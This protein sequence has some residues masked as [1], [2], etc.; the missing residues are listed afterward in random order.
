[1]SHLLWPV[2]LCTTV[3][4]PCTPLL[5]LCMRLPLLPSSS[6]RVYHPC[7]SQAV[8]P[9]LSLLRGHSEELTRPGLT[10]QSLRSTGRDL[11][12]SMCAWRAQRHS[13][14]LA[15]HTSLIKM[16]STLAFSP[17][18]PPPASQAFDLSSKQTAEGGG[19]ERSCTEAGCPVPRWAEG[20]QLMVLR[21]S[22]CNQPP[23]NPAL[24]CH[25]YP[26][27]G[28]TPGRTLRASLSTWNP[29]HRKT[30]PSSLQ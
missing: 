30:L 19:T 26:P 20:C 8:F 1:M 6:P 23:R 24:V 17:P 29:L 25:A 13:G 3:L 21:V 7:I 12:G 15:P 28:G 2:S 14:A 11:H 10:A 9:E 4:P 16:H 5:L 18:E 22:L 27:P